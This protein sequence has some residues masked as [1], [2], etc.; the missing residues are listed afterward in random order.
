MADED[1]ARRDGR[2]YRGKRRYLIMKDVGYGTSMN[3][4]GL[5]NRVPIKVYSN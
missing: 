4:S 2:K 3:E 5:D 1:D